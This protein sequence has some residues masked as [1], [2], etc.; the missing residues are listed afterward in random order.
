ME[1]KP[2]KAVSIIECDMNVSG[3][4]A[5]SAFGPGEDGHSG[6][7]VGHCPRRMSLSHSPWDFLGERRKMLPERNEELTLG[8]RPVGVAEL[9]PV[10]RWLNPSAPQACQGVKLLKN[11]GS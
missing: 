3:F 4:A 2:D 9:L 6:A 5:Y 1:T 8:S 11:Q 7:P 10:R